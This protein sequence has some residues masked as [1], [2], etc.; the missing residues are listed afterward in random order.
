MK[1][2]SIIIFISI[3]VLFIAIISIT[4]HILNENYNENII[5]GINQY[6]IL[7][8]EDYDSIFH[9]LGFSDELKSEVDKSPDEYMMVL[10]NYAVQNLFDNRDIRNIK[11]YLKPNKYMKN[12]IKTFNIQNSISFNEA[13]AMNEAEIGQFVVIKKSGKSENEILDMIR[14]QKVQMVYWPSRA[15]TFSDWLSLLFDKYSFNF[16]VKE[17]NPDKLLNKISAVNKIIFTKQFKCIYIFT[18][19]IALF[20]LH[21]IKNEGIDIFSLGFYT[22]QD[23]SKMFFVYLGV[24]ITIGI[25]ELAHALTL[26]HY[27][28]KVSKIGLKF[29]FLQLIAY[30]DLSELY[31]IDDKKKKIATYSAGILS[32]IFCSSVAIILYNILLIGF[33]NRIDVLI[34]YAMINFGI[35]IFNT[36]P[37]VK[38]DGYWILSTIF[39]SYNLDAKAQAEVKR[40]FKREDGIKSSLVLFGM[41]SILVKGILLLETFNVVISYI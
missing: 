32:Q 11:F 25:H 36:I 28:M 26:V 39:N 4:K 30:C 34:V 23:L 1:K 40:F 14:E 31:L 29:Y 2:K 17:I 21:F 9:D 20:S 16:K 7:P 38:F 12:M 15:G 35:A 5:V 6:K 37:F 41:I 10:L 33:N 18:I 3:S 19:L 24:I 13:D 8:M 22:K 27:N